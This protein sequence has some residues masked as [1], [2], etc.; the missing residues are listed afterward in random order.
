MPRPARTLWRD[1]PR[2][3]GGNDRK[4]PRLSAPHRRRCVLHPTQFPQFFRKS[5]ERCPY[6]C[7]GDPGGVPSGTTNESPAPGCGR[8][9]EF[10]GF[11]AL[12]CITDLRCNCATVFKSFPWGDPTPLFEADRAAKGANP[13]TFGIFGPRYFSTKLFDARGGGPVHGGRGVTNPDATWL[14]APLACQWTRCSVAIGNDGVRPAFSASQTF[15]IVLSRCA[16]GA[17]AASCA[18][19]G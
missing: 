14:R 7:G 1:S 11:H 12:E 8:G 9:L 6:V 3:G 5:A 17:G 15:R 4:A 13:W 18:W 10:R 2:A 19:N 16:V